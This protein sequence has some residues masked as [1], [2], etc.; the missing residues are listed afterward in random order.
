MVA[1]AGLRSMIK[2]ASATEGSS[3][4]VLVLFCLY[5]CLSVDTVKEVVKLSQVKTN[6]AKKKKKKGGGS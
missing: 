3:H 4:N 1:E 6:L 5:K 2:A